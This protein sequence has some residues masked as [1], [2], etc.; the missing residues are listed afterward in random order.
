M[1]TLW[2]LLEATLLCLNAVCVLHEERFLAK[3]RICAF[4][5]LFRKSS[6]SF[7][8]ILFLVGWGVASV[9]QQ[10]FEPPTMKS[11]ALNLIRSIR[12][13]VKSMKTSLLIFK[14]H[15]SLIFPQFLLYSL[16]RWPS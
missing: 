16:I 10:Q 1:F 9:Q 6:N 7:I 12:T 13:V 8:F 5:L 11:Q 3:C 15:Q 2:S 14:I 4:E